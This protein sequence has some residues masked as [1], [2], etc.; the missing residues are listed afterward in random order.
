MAKFSWVSTSI[1]IYYEKLVWKPLKKRLLPQK[2]KFLGHVISSNGIQPNTKRVKDLRNPKSLESKQEVMKVLVCLGFYSCYIR[3]L[4]VDSKPFYN[5][6]RG[7]TSFHWT[8]EHEKIFQ[9][10]KDRISEETILGN[11]STEYPIHIHVDSSN[12]G[13]GCILIQQFLEGKRIISSNSRIFDK[14]EQEMS[15]LHR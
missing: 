10:I 11:P 1:K 6:I 14:V 13:T 7:S 3:N 12:V 8:E 5:L 2:V 9:T 4:H 15:T